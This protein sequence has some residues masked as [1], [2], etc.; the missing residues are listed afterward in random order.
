MN[1]S[2]LHS[3]VIKEILAIEHSS[4]AQTLNLIPDSFNV[5]GTELLKRSIGMLD[6]LSRVDDQNARK[7]VIAVSAILWTYRKDEWEGLR[8]FLI[9]ILSR[10]GFSPS[11]IMV[12]SHYDPINIQF[13]GLNS[14][15]NEMVITVHQLKHEIF[16]GGKKFLITNFQKKVWDKLYSNKLLG[17]S[18]PTSTGK[19]Y[20]IFLKIIDLLLKKDGNVI[21]IVPTLS[22]I[23]Q[24]STDLNNLLKIFEIPNY[25]ISTTY[26]SHDISG[27]K[28]YVLTQEKAISAFSQSNQPFQNVRI[29]VVDEIQNIEKVANEDD[30]RAKTLYDLLIEFRYTSNPDL[31]ILSGPRI[32]GLKELGI[33]IFDEQEADEENTMDSPVASF[34]YAISK[35]HGNYLFKQYS[36]ILDRP[37][38]L[39]ITNDSMIQGFGRSRYS[40]EFLE[41]LF[42]FIKNLGSDSRNIIFSPTSKQARKTA[43][44]LA[45]LQE[46]TPPN[47]L[48]NSLI[49]YIRCTV[50]DE[51]D[52]CR[53][54]PKGFVYHHGK[55]PMHIRSVIERA[56]RDKIVPN[57]VC[58]TT[59]M[60]GV[61]LPAQNVILR[62]PNLA[63]QSRGGEKPKLTDYEIANLRGR[64][65]RLLKDF[66]GRT[67]ILE[68]NSFETEDSQI[69]LF[70]EAEKKLQSGYG[71]KYNIFKDDILTGLQQNETYKDN[72]KEYS[73]LMTYIRHIVI[74]HME[75]SRERLLAVGIE[76]S[77]TQLTEIY[78]TM[79][80][81]HVPREVCLKNRYWDPL[82]LNDLYNQQNMFILPTKISDHNIE[83]NLKNLL[84][85]MRHSFP[86]YYARYFNLDKNLLYTTC[87][88][89]KDWMKEKRLSEILNSDYFDT[90]DKVDEMI[91]R[92]QNKISYGLPM[93][94]KPLYDIK[95]P[96]TMFLRFIEIGAYRPVTRKMIELNVPRET[97]I[98]LNERY[99][100]MFDTKIDDIEGAI[101]IRLR[102]IVKDVD[103]WRRIQIE[104]II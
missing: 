11:A 91:S 96:D 5:I 41:Y 95:L 98:D 104:G 39:A 70:P 50:H 78:T 7:I 6:E 8:E 54:I 103:Y 47:D 71:E 74:K 51:Y 49:D 97:A 30:Q 43:V 61:N 4:I 10:I 85:Q 64:A 65:G 56:I 21:Y 68:E 12:D 63:I 31:T 27:N 29:L 75:N 14:I 77:D 25:R 57:V 86:Q 1:L 13:T 93:L 88:S 84:I 53:T 81:L 35:V 48:V 9:L 19:S 33:S 20:I 24:V 38:R 58:T 18:A 100:K 40:D 42:A 76:L 34:T 66:I 59:L 60:Q 79:Q 46:Q 16:I 99:F 80:E 2:E 101:I 72:N 82:D 44:K 89:A 94:L 83:G 62:N 15:L 90:S 45:E 52:M 23:A 92:L 37:N 22:L 36:S 67:F 28:I 26:N 3:T 73:F 32:T 87:L 69:D 17:I 55:T 102:E